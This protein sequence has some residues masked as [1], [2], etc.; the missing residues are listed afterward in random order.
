MPVLN[1]VQYIGLSLEE[2]EFLQGVF[3]AKTKR[4]RSSYIQL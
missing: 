4:E 2:R 1:H 3:W